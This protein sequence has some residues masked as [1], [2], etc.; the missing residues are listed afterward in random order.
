MRHLVLLGRQESTGWQNRAERVSRGHGR[1]CLGRNVTATAALFSLLLFSVRAPVCLALPRLTSPSLNRPRAGS[2]RIRIGLAGDFLSRELICF[3]PDALAVY[4]QKTKRSSYR[5]SHDA[6]AATVRSTV[7]QSHVCQTRNSRRCSCRSPT[8]AHVH[9]RPKPS[10]EDA[11][12]LR[13]L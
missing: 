11:R 9:S 12:S 3:G 2:R 7:Q 10:R 4:H 13:C 6:A 5:E 1:R 8:T